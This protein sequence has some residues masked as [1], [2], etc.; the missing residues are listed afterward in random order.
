[1]MHVAE[2]MPWNGE[3]SQVI[4]TTIKN[5]KNASEMRTSHQRLLMYKEKTMWRPGRAADEISRL[6]VLKA[7][8]SL[9]QHSSMTNS[10]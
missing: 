4:F 2:R 1:M 5:P 8:G 10:L 3:S 9:A 7:A 6:S